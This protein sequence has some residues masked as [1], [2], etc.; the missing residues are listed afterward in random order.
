[1][2][3]KFGIRIGGKGGGYDDIKKLFK[4]DPSLQGEVFNELLDIYA[5]YDIVN[6]SSLCEGFLK[7]FAEGLYT[8]Y[9]K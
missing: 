7:N 6:G 4:K 5:D 1:M 3:D 9:P 2:W 8:K